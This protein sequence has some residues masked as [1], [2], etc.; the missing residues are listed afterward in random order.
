MAEYLHQIHF[1]SEYLE[2][3][4]SLIQR[5]VVEAHLRT[6]AACRQELTL[7][8][9][10]VN[11]L[12]KL[13]LLT[14]P[15]DFEEKFHWQIEQKTKGLQN[16]QG[17]DA[18]TLA[19]EQ[20]PVQETTTRAPAAAPSPITPLL[21]KTSRLRYIFQFPLLVQ[22]Q[23][24]ACVA[25]LGLSIVLSHIASEEPTLDP[26]Q[27]TLQVTSHSASSSQQGMTAA[28]NTI[29]PIDATIP[30]PKQHTLSSTAE[31]P[32]TNQPLRWRVAGSEPAL[33]RRQVKEL[34]GQIE[35]AALV[36]EQE[37]LLLISLPTQKLGL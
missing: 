32:G 34:A 14:T 7:L 6:C 11:I 27:S 1:L 12:Q 30:S 4:P 37:D 36:Q 15:A 26:E 5:Q 2:G 18:R 23:L 8:R 35:G 21:R 10:M 28:G 13:P 17:E 19:A 9:Q 20:L 24:Y 3:E 33:L 31:T 29:Q 22:I 25:L 16:T